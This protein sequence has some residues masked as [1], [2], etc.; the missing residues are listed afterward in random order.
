MKN[1]LRLL[2]VQDNS[3]GHYN[4]SE[5]V[6]KAIQR[7]HACDV[8]RMRAVKNS[9]PSWHLLYYLYNKKILPDKLFLKMAYDEFVCEFDPDIIVSAGGDTLLLN[10]ILSKLYRCKNI[11]SG[12]VRNLDRHLFSAILI[13]Y[14][15]YSGQSP[16]IECLKPSPI[17]PDEPSKAA[18]RFDFCFLIGGPSG[19]HSYSGDDWHR[20]LLLI[21][22]MAA[23]HSVAVFSSR[24]TPPDIA[25]QLRQVQSENISFFDPAD[26]GTVELFDYCKRSSGI[27]VTEDSNSMITEAVCCRKPVLALAPARTRMNANEADYLA[28]LM[29][30]NWLARQV[31]DENAAVH[32]LITKLDALQPMRSNHL[33]ILAKKLQPLLPIPA[34]APVMS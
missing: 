30:K 16:F 9:I 32:E 18:Q 24:R 28:G 11:F 19:T 13:P 3:P 31:L 2:I 17:D 27:I 4:Q 25:V 15:R 23:S 1:P 5:G 12:S 8:A 20:L 7:V 34:S 6:A 22:Q 29:S 21:Q 10:V 14:R 33:D 26:A